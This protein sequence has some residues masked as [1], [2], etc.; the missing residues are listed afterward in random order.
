MFTVRVLWIAF[1]VATLI[2]GFVAW[3]SAGSPD[4]P[5]VDRGPLLADPLLVALALAALAAA[6]AERVVPPL[7]LTP[8]R[9][10]AAAESDLVIQLA[11]NT[12]LDPADIAAITALPESEQRAFKLYG[13]W[14]TAMIVRWACSEVIA[15]C[16][17]ILAFLRHDPGL[18]VPFGAVSLLLLLLAKPQ[19]DDLL[20]LTRPGV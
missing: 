10:R 19:L 1:V 15:L 17:L 4:R 13:P 8:D 9:R 18:F 5:Y 12:R 3:M 14:Q 11:R 20:A 7:M 2:Y 16:G 6:I